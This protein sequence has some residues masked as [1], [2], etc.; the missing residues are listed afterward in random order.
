M[1]LHSPLGA[2]SAYRWLHCPGSFRLSESAPSR[3]MTI[4]SATGVLAH[5]LIEG[6]LRNGGGLAVDLLGHRLAVGGFNEMIE[7]T[8]EL[9]DGVQVMIDYVEDRIAGST[10]YDF[11]FR[12]S[13]DGHFKT[14]PPVPVFGTLDAATLNGVELEVIDYKNGAGVFVSPIENPQLMFYAAGVLPILP[15]LPT[16]AV[17]RV[18]MTIVQPHAPG[19]EKIRSWTIDPVDLSMW[20]DNVLVPGVAAAADPGAALVTG[21]WCRFCPVSQACPALHAAAVD[22]AQK[23]FDDVDVPKDP[24]GLASL[25]DTA[26]KAELWIARLREFAKAALE[27]GTLIPGWGLIPTRP[28]RKWLMD[29]Q[30]IAARL[31]ALGLDQMTIFD[32]RLRSPAQIDTILHKSR[33]GTRIWDDV[34]LMVESRSSGSKV[35][36]TGPA[37]KDEFNDGEE[38]S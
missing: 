9:L 38:L 23:Q 3:P 36:R 19:S 33:A 4:H 30:S 22:L 37:A 5:R 28:S 8:Q 27:G 31:A 15:I 35:G 21:A 34:N 24:G 18:K 10:W 12:V 2:S 17:Q 25:L 29:D 16:G 20:V 7:V 1:T 14:P 6:G 13:L 26:E 32:T 11:E